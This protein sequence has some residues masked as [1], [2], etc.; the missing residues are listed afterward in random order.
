MAMF[1]HWLKRRQRG[2]IFGK[3]LKFVLHIISRD[4]REKTAKWSDLMN[5]SA[6][7]RKYRDQGCITV[8]TL[9]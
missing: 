8:C 1:H 2:D 5:Y 7:D 6:N 9:T 4:E 3:K